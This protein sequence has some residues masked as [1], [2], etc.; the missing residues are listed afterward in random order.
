MRGAR[1]ESSR[2]DVGGSLGEV[3]GASDGGKPGSCRLCQQWS[4]VSMLNGTLPG[5]WKQQGRPVIPVDHGS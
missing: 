3:V 5:A 1:L 2:V 4:L